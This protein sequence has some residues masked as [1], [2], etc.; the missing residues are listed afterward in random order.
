MARYLW[1]EIGRLTSYTP[2]ASDG[3]SGAAY[4]YRADGMRIRKVTG[5][6]MWWNEPNSQEAGY[7]TDETDLGAPTY[8]YFYDGQMCFEDDYTVAQPKNESA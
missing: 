8:R 4:A 3:G 5:Q 1:D 6:F 7:Y 2:E